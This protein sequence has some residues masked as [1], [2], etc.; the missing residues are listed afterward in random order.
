MPIS[1]DEFK[2]GRKYDSI[3]SKIIEFLE[4]NNN[5]AYTSE[6]IEKGIKD[7]KSTIVETIIPRDFVSVIVDGF[8]EMFESNKFENALER[9]VKDNII[10]AKNVK[11]GTDE[12]IYYKIKK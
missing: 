8:L 9:L 6:E 7:K 11:I 4:K 1:I 10:E 3:E 2:K 12:K 5:Q